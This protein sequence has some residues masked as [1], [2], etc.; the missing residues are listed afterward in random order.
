MNSRDSVRTGVGWILVNGCGA[1]V[2]RDNVVGL[3]PKTLWLLISASNLPC[4]HPQTIF[5][6]M[7]AVRYFPSSKPRGVGG[8]GQFQVSDYEWLYIVACSLQ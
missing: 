4:I 8:G 1:V 5:K 7:N 6:D 2:I 3:E